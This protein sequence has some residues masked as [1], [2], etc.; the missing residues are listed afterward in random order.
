MSE[1]RRI[2]GRLAVAFRVRD[3]EGLCRRWMTGRS[4]LGG[5]I[6]QPKERD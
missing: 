2:H 3:T 5:Q 1:V 4:L 6:V